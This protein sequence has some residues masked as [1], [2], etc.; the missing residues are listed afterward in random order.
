MT[1]KRHNYITDLA[2]RPISA[3]ER[4]GSGRCACIPVSVPV[5]V[6]PPARLSALEAMRTGAAGGP[7]LPRERFKPPS[8]GRLPMQSPPLLAAKRPHLR[9]SGLPRFP[10]RHLSVIPASP[11]REEG[12]LSKHPLGASGASAEGWAAAGEGRGEPDIPPPCHPPGGSRAPLPEHPGS[13]GSFTP[14]ASLPFS[15]FPFSS[16]PSRPGVSPGNGSPACH[17]LR[18]GRAAAAR[19]RAS[20]AV[21]SPGMH[22]AAP[23]LGFARREEKKIG[24]KFTVLLFSSRGGTRDKLGRNNRR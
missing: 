16:H 19:L 1:T 7:Q 24:Q 12:L 21:L 2:K 6:P 14:P 18:P 13:A 8:P 3:A 10:P 15:S 17:P 4:R 5:P 20:P 22:R 23:P 9:L 11:G